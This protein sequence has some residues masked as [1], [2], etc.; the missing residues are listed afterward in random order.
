MTREHGKTCI[1]GLDQISGAVV[2]CC[3]AFTSKKGGGKQMRDD[4]FQLFPQDMKAHVDLYEALFAGYF[5][6]MVG[7]MAAL[8]LKRFYEAGK[9]PKTSAFRRQ[10]TYI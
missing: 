2:G 6:L 10:S 5:P 4:L 1:V 8:W 3:L 7:L 9:N